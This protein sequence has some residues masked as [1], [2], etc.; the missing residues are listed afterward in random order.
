MKI[1]NL[2]RPDR[3][4]QTVPAPTKLSQSSLLV[5]VSILVDVGKGQYTVVV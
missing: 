3:W 4:R 1:Q 5:Q 2:S